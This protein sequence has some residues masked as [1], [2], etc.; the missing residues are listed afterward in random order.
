MNKG[1]IITLIVFLLL[2]IGSSLSAQ[3]GNYESVADF[4]PPHMEI[5]Q[6]KNNR[7]Y[8][9]NGLKLSQS[10]KLLIADYGFNNSLIAI[11]SIDSLKL[12]GAY[13]IESI[14]ELEHSYFSDDDTKLYIKYNRFSSDYKLITLASKTMR[15]I[16]CDKTPQGC[17]SRQAG[18]SIVKLYSPDKKYYFV[19]NSKDRKTLHIYKLVE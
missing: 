15:N 16:S 18:M 7:K 19:R 2:G 12:V 13:W 9:L 11:Y 14:A 17:I 4:E 3:K 6:Y 5:A 10:G 1:L 8:Q